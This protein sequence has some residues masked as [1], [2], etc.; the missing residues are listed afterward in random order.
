MVESSGRRESGA[1]Q[2]QRRSIVGLTAGN[3]SFG[4]LCSGNRAIASFFQPSSSLLFFSF[5]FSSFILHPSSPSSSVLFLSSSL[6]PLQPLPTF[7]QKS[8][9]HCIFQQD[10]LHS[11]QFVLGLQEQLPR[12]LPHRHEYVLFLSFSLT[13]LAAS[14]ATGRHCCHPLCARK[15]SKETMQIQRISKQASEGSCRT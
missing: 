7:Q 4:W 5:P 9:T 2:I 8:S 12:R 10:D 15:G 11:Q 3:F 14:N 6:F 1:R 13:E